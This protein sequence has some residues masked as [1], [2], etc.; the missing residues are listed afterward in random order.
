[1]WGNCSLVLEPVCGFQ[2]LGHVDREGLVPQPSSA[3]SSWVWGGR[4]DFLQAGA[5]LLGECGSLFPCVLTLG[6]V[7]GS[8]TR[9]L[10]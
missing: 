3:R 2:G 5:L 9:G 6:A 1:M 4:E 7:G 8:Q 10:W